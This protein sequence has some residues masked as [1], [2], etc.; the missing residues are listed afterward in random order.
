MI[1]RVITHLAGRFTRCRNCI[2]EP[3]HI[4]TAGR[5]SSEPVLFFA[6]A[7]RHS[8]ECSCGS[9]TARHETLAAAECEWGSDYAQLALPLPM[10]TQ[11]RRRKVGAA[12]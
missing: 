5:S 10:R 7:Q 8:L 9:R 1:E 4:R 3:R 12:A 2:R 11:R 6:T